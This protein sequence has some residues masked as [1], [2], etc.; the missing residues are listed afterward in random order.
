MSLLITKQNSS[1]TSSLLEKKSE[2]GKKPTR[3]YSKK[4]EDSVAEAI[5]GI[6]NLNSGATPFI[7]G[8]CVNDQWLIE[9]KTKT[10]SSD[11]IS[12]KKDWIEKNKQEA[13]FMGKQYSAV[14]ISFG[15]NEP[16]YY[17]IDEYLFQDLIEY[18]NM[19]K[20]EQL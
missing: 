12:V 3:Y 10:K 5:G 8:D 16:N 7:K 20:E 14:A 18:L 19:K 15:P 1:K 6:R 17:V 2:E 11:N 4:Q 9:C 13:L